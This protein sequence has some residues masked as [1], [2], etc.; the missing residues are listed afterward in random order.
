MWAWTLPLEHRKLLPQG[1]DLQAKI[2][3]GNQERTQ[4]REE[5]EDK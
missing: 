1:K 2:V 5:S 4:V 3:A